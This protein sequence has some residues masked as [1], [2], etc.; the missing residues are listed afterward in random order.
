MHLETTNEN[1]NTELIDDNSLFYLSSE[2]LWNVDNLVDS[3]WLEHAPFAFWIVNALKPKMLVELGAHNGFSYFSF[4]QA[5]QRLNLRTVCYAIDTWQGDDH[6]GFYSDEVF[7]GINEYNQKKYSAFSQLIRSTFDDAVKYFV[8]GSIDLLHID[9]R[10]FYEDVKHD[11]EIWRSKLSDKAIVLFH[12]VN[13]RERDFG[14]FQLWDELKQRYP[15]FEFLHG[16]GLGVL[17]VGQSIPVVMQRLFSSVH[18]EKISSEI[19][20]AYSRLGASISEKFR[21]E[22]QLAEKDKM[23][24]GK[25]AHIHRLLNSRSWKYTQIL[26]YICTRLKSL[27]SAGAKANNFQ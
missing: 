16:H 3:A 7:R 15:Y 23:L 13:V 20:Q 27:Q 17:G 8:D 12:D 5:V 10:H 25:E 19:C 14:V 24:V 26:R 2:S 9:G 6:A 4:C 21:L 18:N 1:T 11:F 22:S